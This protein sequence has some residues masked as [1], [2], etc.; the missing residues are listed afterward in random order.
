M[1]WQVNADPFPSYL[2]SVQRAF[3]VKQDHP[4]GSQQ[5]KG[6]ADPVVVANWEDRHPSRTEW[7]SQ[8]CCYRRSLSPCTKVKSMRRIKNK[9]PLKLLDVVD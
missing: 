2:L 5:L 9:E 6:L 8:S 4:F 7:R 1:T 3:C